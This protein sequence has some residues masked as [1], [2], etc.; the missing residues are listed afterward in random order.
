MAAAFF[1]AAEAGRL[2]LAVSAGLALVTFAYTFRIADHQDVGR[3]LGYELMQ[4]VVVL[5]G[6]IAA[7]DALRSRRRGKAEQ[8]R[9]ARET[10]ARKQEEAL[11]IIETERS[12]IAR[13]VHDVVAHTI[14]VIRLHADIAAETVTD[15]PETATAAVTQISAAAR[16]AMDELRD[17]LARIAAA[18]DQGA[19]RRRSA[20]GAHGF[21]DPARSHP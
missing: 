21:T 4:S 7:G 5:A 20:A 3:L 10:V 15:D 9:L 12:Q 6:A 2:R 16:S 8:E 17:S 1:S 18:A 14:A 11:R 13:D 19:H